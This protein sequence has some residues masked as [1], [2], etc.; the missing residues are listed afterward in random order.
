MSFLRRYFVHFAFMDESG[1]SENC[2]IA[3]FGAL[4]CPPE[5][6]LAMEHTANIAAVNLIPKERRHEF[7]EFHAFDLYKGEGVFRDIPEPDRFE[8]IELLL[9]V[10]EL[11]SPRFVYSA[12][13]RSKF[14]GSCAAGTSANVLTFAFKMCL[15]EVEEFQ[16]CE[17][18]RAY[19]AKQPVNKTLGFY[20]VDDILDKTRKD[21]LKA[22]YRRLRTKA[23]AE[24][25][26]TDR[27]LWY[28]HDAISFQ[29]SRDSIG[30]QVADLCAFF[31]L[32]NLQRREEQDRFFDEFRRIVVCSKQEPE[33]SQNADFLIEHT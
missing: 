16:R 21:P 15:L 2:P 17:A 31:T 27:R 30:L 13:D 33:W 5:W 26:P 3:L 28:A 6:V 1:A 23:L 10:A 24:P 19:V 22:E 12:V 25:N 20:V 14:R 32:G 4:I 7:E 11:H 8:T 18:A 29:D 9:G